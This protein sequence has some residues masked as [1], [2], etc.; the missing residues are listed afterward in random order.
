M[1]LSKTFTTKE[2]ARL[3]RVSDAT[4]KRWEDA[5]IIRS[6][7]T[8]GG[9]RRFR[10]EEVARFQRE[11]GL[12]LK[13]THGDVSVFGINHR[14]S[15]SRNHSDLSLFD[16]LLSGSEAAATEILIG[17]HLDGKPPCEIFDETLCPALRK[18]GEKWFAGEI[19]VAQEHLATRTVLNAIYKLRSHLPVPEPT[20]KLAVCCALE[21]EFHELPTHLAQIT[22]ENE[23]WEVLNFG[24]NTP[25]YCLTE[26][27][28]R[29][30]PDMVCISSTII[31]DIER[32][33]RDFINFRDLAAKHKISLVLGGR[34]FDADCMRKRFPADFY[35]QSFA[36]VAAFARELTVK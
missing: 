29:H 12:G 6:E 28:S 8:N 7:R 3:C 11:Q 5:G 34:V 15:E 26:E 4:V 35:A 14:N 23:G 21:N 27:I 19:S 30:L 20:G 36:E 10:A 18:I 13:R 9:H 25:L 33:S 22:I 2:V 32:L 31:N 1:S 24:A 17:D 16:A